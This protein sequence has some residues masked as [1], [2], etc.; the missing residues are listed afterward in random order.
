M[1]SSANT[2]PLPRDDG[3]PMA[4][5]ESTGDRR[6][7]KAGVRPRILIIFSNPTCLNLGDVAMLKI[8]LRRLKRHWAGA[9]FGVMTSDPVALVRHCPE[10][11]AV[12]FRDDWLSD[13]LLFGGLH[14]RLPSSL[15]QALVAVQDRAW[16]EFPGLMTS[17]CARRLAA[18]PSDAAGLRSYMAW[19]RDSDLVIACG[20]GGLNDRFRS[21]ASTLLVSLGVAQA[22]GKGTAMFGHG[23]GPITGAW[24]RR[25]S[26]SVLSRVRLLALR[27]GT[28]GPKIVRQLGVDQERWTITGDDAIELAHERRPMSLGGCLGLNIRV[29]GSS[30]VDECWAAR[31]RPMVGNFLREVGV[32]LV[33]LPI[34]RQGGLDATAIR[35]ATDSGAGVDEDGWQSQT[36]EDV[37]RNAAKCRLVVT[38]AYHAAVFALSQGIPA[39][40]LFQSAYFRAKFEGLAELFGEGCRLV[41][42]GSPDVDRA[43]PAVMRDL[44]TRAPGLREGLLGAAD[45]QVVLGR[46]AYES[47]CEENKVS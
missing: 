10:A 29:G 43:L 44:W 39:I 38:G 2:K 30:G 16:R 42:L 36:P 6:N 1:I 28:L 12:L 7:L 47:F 22:L 45:K 34:A 25:R 31:L 18:S 20:A 23:L 32:P 37:I 8:A 26:A 40:C 5:S 9:R 21:Y 27:E 33:A 14:R 3:N 24:L 35:E 4:G 46:R 11:E 13:R 19:L 41:D 17:V 15:S